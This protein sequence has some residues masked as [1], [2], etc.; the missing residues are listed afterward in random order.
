MD[1]PSAVMTLDPVTAGAPSLTLRLEDGTV[2]E[3]AA[4]ERVDP[5]FAWL[6]E[7]QEPYTPGE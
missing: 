6:Q 2:L 7:Q 1:I 3:G 4:G 5:T